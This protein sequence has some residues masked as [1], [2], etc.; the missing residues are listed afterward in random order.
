MPGQT[1]MVVPDARPDLTV[2]SLLWTLKPLYCEH[3]GTHLKNN[4]GGFYSQVEAFFF[5]NGTIVTTVWP[6]LVSS[7]LLISSNN[8]REVLLSGF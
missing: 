5:S 1:K 3:S 8:A 6:Y 7:Q 4:N 2:V